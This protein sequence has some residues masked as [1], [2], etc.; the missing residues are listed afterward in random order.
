MESLN[1]EFINLS[2]ENIL[3]EHLSCVIRSRK[4]HP[5]VEAKRE[6][7]AER[8]KEDHVFR[9]AKAL[10]NVAKVCAKIRL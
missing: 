5:G 6:W 9:K 3:T 7:L 10:A 8:I 4:P 1:P 2:S